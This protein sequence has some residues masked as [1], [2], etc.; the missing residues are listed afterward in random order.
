MNHTAACVQHNIEKLDVDGLSA[1]NAFAT[2]RK[3]AKDRQEHG[4]CI[5][6]KNHK[7]HELFWV[8]SPVMVSWFIQ[9]GE[10]LFHKAPDVEFTEPVE[11]L[12]Y[13][14]TCDTNLDEMTVTDSQVTFK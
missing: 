5:C 1:I 3:M 14:A 12:I 9:D 8:Q 4:G 7:G 10:V 11:Q 6:P 2:L 13:C